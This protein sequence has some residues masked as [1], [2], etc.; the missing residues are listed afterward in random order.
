MNI[1]VYVVI[2]RTT[3]FIYGI[4]HNLQTALKILDAAV[5]EDPNDLISLSDEPILA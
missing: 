2:N 3:G 1:H 5:D 4:T